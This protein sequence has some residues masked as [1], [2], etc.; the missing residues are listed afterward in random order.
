MKNLLLLLTVALLF[1]CQAKKE[2]ADIKS[3]TVEA[4]SFQTETMFEITC[5]K[6]DTY[7]SDK[8]R[9]KTITD[10]P[11]I[12]KFSN[13]L[14]GLKRTNDNYTPNVRIK[15]LLASSKGVVDTVCMDDKITRYKGG[16]YE[17]TVEFANFVQE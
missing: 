14:S 17:T 16:S 9:S 13:L 3:V 7:Y 6:F 11:T 8:W 5:E 15:L 12:D 2:P 1:G 10:K 4:I